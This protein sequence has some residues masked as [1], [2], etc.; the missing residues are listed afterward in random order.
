M[1]IFHKTAVC[2]LIVSS[3]AFAATAKAS[4]TVYDYTHTGA[5]GEDPFVTASVTLS[6]PA[7]VSTT[8]TALAVGD[9]LTMTGSSYWSASRPF[10]SSASADTT[11]FS[12]TF[13]ATGAVTEWSIALRG[14]VVDGPEPELFETTS[15]CIPNLPDN[16][17][18][19]ATTIDDNDG[20]PFDN[21]VSGSHS[22]TQS[23]P[24]PIG[25]WT[26]S[27]PAAVPE[28]STLVVWSLLGI[29]G[30]GFGWRR[31]RKAA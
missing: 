31:R 23:N 4:I 28:P 20:V 2:F 12:M 13:D 11:W 24:D 22:V 25:V 5:I 16:P 10:L 30:I 29:C 15:N 9:S 17:Y 21:Y 3:L 8:L 6:G 27:E 1:T 7:P 18:F 26:I 19:D 14:D